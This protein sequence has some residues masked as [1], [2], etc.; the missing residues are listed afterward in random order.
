MEN[1]NTNKVLSTENSI[2][3][4]SSKVYNELLLNSKN[5]ACRYRYNDGSNVVGRYNDY[6]FFIECNRNSFIRV[7]FFEVDDKSKQFE[8]VKALY[9]IGE[10]LGG[11][12]G[13]P[14]V[15]YDRLILYEDFN[16]ET[17]NPTLE[18]CLDKK[19]EDEIVRNIVNDIHLLDDRSVNV[20]LF[21]GKRIEYYKDSSQYV[22]KK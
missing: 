1:K 21:T 16:V 14:T 19:N 18:W 13:T 12:Y 8:M 15:Y 10:I 9:D 7:T 3:Y 22:L 20:R 4:D 2:S 5:G 17:V 11:I 6:S